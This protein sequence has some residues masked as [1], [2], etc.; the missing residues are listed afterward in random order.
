MCVRHGTRFRRRLSTRYAGAAPHPALAEQGG[1]R[2]SAMRLI[3]VPPSL[4]EETRILS[5]PLSR[6]RRFIGVALIAAL[7]HTVGLSILI[8]ASLVFGL[9]DGTEP[10]LLGADIRVSSTFQAGVLV[11]NI[12]LAIYHTYRFPET[13]PGARRHDLLHSALMA[14]GRHSLLQCLW[15][16]F[17]GST[18]AFFFFKPHQPNVNA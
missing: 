17:L 7:V 16:L 6:Y 3:E 15:S 1:V 5:V 11:L 14:T 10:K 4:K 9:T 12:P 2:R 18:V 8:R 13:T